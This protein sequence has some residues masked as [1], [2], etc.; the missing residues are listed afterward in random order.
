MTRILMKI[1]IQGSLFIFVW[2]IITNDLNMKAIKVIIA[3][4]S[5]LFLLAYCEKD[6]EIPT[7]FPNLSIDSLKILQTNIPGGHLYRPYFH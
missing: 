3:F 5:P 4:L 1:F 6:S 7:D 2:S